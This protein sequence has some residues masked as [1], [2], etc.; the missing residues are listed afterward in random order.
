MK[1]VASIYVL[2]SCEIKFLGRIA[3]IRCEIFRSDRRI[4][5]RNNMEFRIKI[6]R[7]NSA[8]VLLFTEFFS[9]GLTDVIPKLIILEC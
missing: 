6:S 9:C 8:H 5:K 4:V 1:V 3:P 2:N 7:A